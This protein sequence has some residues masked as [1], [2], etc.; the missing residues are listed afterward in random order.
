MKLTRLLCPWDSPGKNTGVSC[1]VLLPGIF[2]TQG[3]NPGLPHCRQI[4]YLPSHQGRPKTQHSQ[5]NKIKYLKYQLITDGGREGWKQLLVRTASS[6][7]L[8]QAFS[9]VGLGDRV[10]VSEAECVQVDA[11]KFTL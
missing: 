5:I 9:F 11:V 6:R 2:L 1:H 7:Q 8:S 4:L 10:R 3:L